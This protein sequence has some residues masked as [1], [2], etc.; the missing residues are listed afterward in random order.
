MHKADRIIAVSNFTKNKIMTHYGVPSEKINV[1]HNAVDFSQHYY[2]ENFEIKKTDK[3]VLF[4]GR[5]TLQKGPDYF[6][7]AAK[8]VLEQEKNVKFVIAG[9]GDM[10]PFIIEKAAELGIADKVLFAGFLNQDYVER[11]YK[12]ADVYVMPSVSEPFGI[13]ALEAMKNKT[14]TIVSKQSGVSEVVRHCLKADFWD[15]N[16]LSNKIITL[17]RY[18]TLHETLKDNGYL[19]VKKFSWDVPAQK[20]IDIYNELITKDF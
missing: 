11:A 13:T 1:V 16:E 20:C 4:L 2:D 17:L 6:V 10:E 19:E 3:V 7:Y 15:V 14:P 9:S 12:M 5:I 18:P 8:K